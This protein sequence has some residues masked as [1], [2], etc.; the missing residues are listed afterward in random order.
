MAI[1]SY[2]GGFFAWLYGV[3]FPVAWVFFLIAGGLAKL[4][5][6]GWG[7]YNLRVYYKEDPP[8]R[9]F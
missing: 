4:F 1:A 5:C 8:A 3:A 2:F 9:R 6:C 7:A